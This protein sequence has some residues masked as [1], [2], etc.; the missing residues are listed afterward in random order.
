M[1]ENTKIAFEVVDKKGHCIHQK[2]SPAEVKGLHYSTLWVISILLERGNEEL[3]EIGDDIAAY[4]PHRNHLGKKLVKVCFRDD[5]EAVLLW[6]HELGKNRLKELLDLLIGV[7]YI[8]RFDS[9]QDERERLIT[10]THTGF[11]KLTDLTLQR[12]ENMSELFKLLRI[13]KSEYGAFV[14]KFGKVSQRAWKT[15]QREYLDAK[16]SR[17]PMEEESDKS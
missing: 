13:P 2:D 11:T 12:K 5:I 6:K 4:V 17:G 1:A 3:L 8:R 10:I 16:N 9:T 14:K 7:G 15:M